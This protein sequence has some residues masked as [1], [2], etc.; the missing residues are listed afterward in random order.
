MSVP[1]GSVVSNQTETKAEPRA[2][3]S[4]NGACF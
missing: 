3:K 1:L 4:K 2:T